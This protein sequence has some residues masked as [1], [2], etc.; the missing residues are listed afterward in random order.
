MA[1]GLVMVKTQGENYILIYIFSSR[2]FYMPPIILS[3]KNHQSE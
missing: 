3:F 1:F 2:Y